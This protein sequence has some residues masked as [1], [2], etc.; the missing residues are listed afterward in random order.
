MGRMNKAFVKEIED[1]GRRHCPACG[2]LG[3]GV[4]Q[5]TLVAHLRPEALAGLS[6]TGY[7][8]PFENCDVVYFDDFERTATIGALV[9]PVFPKHPDAPLCACFG[10]T[11]DDIEQDVREGVV[12]RTRSVVERAKTAEARCH[13]LAADGQPC[14]GAVQRCYMK[15]AG[16]DTA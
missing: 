7:F 10:L 12:T 13:E 15:L 11:R 3:V 4:R 9:N 2:S 16:R 5:E 14:V 6:S 8:C 1:T